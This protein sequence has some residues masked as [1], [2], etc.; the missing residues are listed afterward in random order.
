MSLATYLPTARVSRCVPPPPG[1]QAQQPFG[2]AEARACRADDDVTAERQLE[3]ATERIAMHRRDSW[4]W[5]RFQ[6][7][8]DAPAVELIGDESL[9]APTAVF[10]NVGT[11]HEG[12]PARAGE[13]DCAHFRIAGQC[14]Q[15]LVQRVHERC[16]QRV[17]LGRTVEDN[18]D[19]ARLDAFVQQ[20]PFFH[21]AHP[22]TAPAVRPATN[23]RC[24]RKKIATT[25]SEISTELAISSP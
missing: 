8:E 18:A 3:A 23:W 1:R 17:H 19:D 6:L 10:S 4:L 5:H 24:R 9:G 12:A 20:D 25:G 22:F 13:D 16:R 11:R 7:V 14:I 21:S 15:C 2:Q